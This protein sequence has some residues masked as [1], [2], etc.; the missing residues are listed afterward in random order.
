MRKLIKPVVSSS[1]LLER[2]GTE[3]GPSGAAGVWRHA[4]GT[5]RHHFSCTAA[6][7]LLAVYC[8][9]T[10]L[11]WHR[12][13]GLLHCGALVCQYHH[14]VRPN[15]TT[16]CPVFHVHAERGAV[17][18]ITRDGHGL[19]QFRVVEIGTE[20]LENIYKSRVKKQNVITIHLSYSLSLIT[21]GR[22][23]TERAACMHGC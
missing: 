4:G 6:G 23:L 20:S 17:D 14:T 8:L 9:H 5:H 3:L 11:G 22:L 15:C 19:L 18:A 16:V 13:A 7:P 1:H 10:V 12:A 21:A 2:H